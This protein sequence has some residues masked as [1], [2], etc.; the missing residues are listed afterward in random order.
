[1]QIPQ[2]ILNKWKLSLKHGEIETISESTGIT[3]NC[4]SNA[5]KNGNCETETFESIKKYFKEKA[6]K[7]IALIKEALQK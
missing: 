3:R 5:L 1:M 6:E 4:V 7:E 2:P